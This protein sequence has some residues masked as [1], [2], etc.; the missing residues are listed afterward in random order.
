MMNRRHFLRTAG[1]TPILALS[2]GAGLA[3]TSDYRAV[4]CLF[5]AGG[6]DGHNSLVPT[7][8]AYDDYQKSRPGLALA[9]AELKNLPGSSAGHT[10]GM[11]PA[12]APLLPAYN[13]GRLAWLLNAGPLVMPATAQQVLQRSVTVPSFLLSHSDQVMWQQGWL[14]DADGSGWGGRAMELLPSA[15]RN[16][17]NAVTMNTSRTL[18]LGRSS[19][20]SF[21]GPWGSRYWGSADLAQQGSASTQALMRM[22]QWQYGGQYQA[23]YARTFGRSLQESALV[24]Q[25]TLNAPEPNGAFD[26]DDLGQGMRRLATVMPVFRK[27]GYKRQLF[28]L[29]WGN[30]DTHAAQRGTAVYSQDYQLAK[31]ARNIA[32][33]DA[34]NKASGIDSGVVLLIMSDFGRTLRQASGNG[35]DHAWGNNWF[36]LGTPVAGGQVY[37][38]LPTLKLGGVDDADRNGEGRFA[39]SMATDQVGATLMRW[40]GLPDSQLTAAFPN[41]V[42]FSTRT[43]NFL[44]A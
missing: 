18:V 5:L 23:E 28:L 12:L 19:P 33:L 29:Q 8:G 6:N 15:L 42:N 40:L 9:K 14:G 17:M 36:V 4:V 39:P 3:A 13:E 16:P 22:A 21:L 1:A 38:T 31:V 44:H 25:A 24:T 26:S 20:V 10:F 35:T 11:N 43:L 37:G 27:L 7:D 41:L 32:A 34:A 30:F 2:G